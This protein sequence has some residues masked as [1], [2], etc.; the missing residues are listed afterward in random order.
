MLNENARLSYERAISI[1][2]GQETMN[3]VNVFPTKRLS[4]FKAIENSQQQYSK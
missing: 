1:K 3:Y 2:N 4:I